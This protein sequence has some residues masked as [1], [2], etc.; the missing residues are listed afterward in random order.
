[1]A[2]SCRRGPTRGQGG[3]PESAEHGQRL[4][5]ADV[6]SAETL[7]SIVVDWNL[8]DLTIRCVTSLVDAGVPP[9]RIVVVENGPTPE[10]WVRTSS[11]L[12]SC[13]LVRVA[14]NVG[15]A[16]ASNIAAGLLPGSAYLLVNNDAWVRRPGS[17]D[18]LVQ[19]LRRPGIGIAVPRLLN[20]DLTLQ[21]TV[22]PFTTPLPA[23]VRASGLSRLVPDRWRPRVSTHWSHRWSRE[24]E[25]AIGA[26][27]LVDGA[28]WGHL[29]GLRETSFMYSEDLD[30]CWR[31]RKAGWKTWF[32]AEAE[33]VHSGGA[34]ADR[35]WGDRERWERIARAE[36]EMIREHLPPVQA[37]IALA[38]TRAGVAA[39]AAWFGLVGDASAAARYRGFF[40]GLAQRP[41]GGQAEEVVPA[42][43]EVVGPRSPRARERPVQRLP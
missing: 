2:Q 18:A 1:M 43:V 38:A 5:L 17:V 33:F 16:R 8:P 32:S 7:T 27:M 30:L 4:P 12:S 9:E 42:Q 29:G 26:V 40:D 11:Q 24:V 25:A 21:P 3:E 39:R 37:R 19:A 15:F 31:A 14:D 36:G 41:A 22:A 13:M 23:L 34:S 20:D 6:T 10:N 35:R 28:V